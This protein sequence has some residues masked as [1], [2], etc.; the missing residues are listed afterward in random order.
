MSAGAGAAAAAAAIAQA[1]KASGVIVHVEPGDFL[2]I[3]RRQQGA[4][5][6]HAV[7]GFFTTSYQYLTSYKGLAFFAKS[8]AP[9][10]LPSG[11]ELVQAKKIWIP[12]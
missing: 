9:L 11:T 12:G 2:G 7:G 6:V 1:I 10:T 4:L 5:V 8:S 3:L